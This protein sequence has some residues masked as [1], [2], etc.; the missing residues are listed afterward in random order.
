MLHL[1][2][3]PYHVF[4][5]SVNFGK[6]VKSLTFSGREFQVVGP[7]VFR[8]FSLKVS[9]FALLTTKSFFFPCRVGTFLGISVREVWI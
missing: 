7:N 9:F 6:E 1:H 8:L 2:S 5:N 3:G 4:T